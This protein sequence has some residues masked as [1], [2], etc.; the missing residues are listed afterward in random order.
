M[1][2]VGRVAVCVAVF[3]TVFLMLLIA[4]SRAVPQSAILEALDRRVT[5]VRAGTADEVADERVIQSGDRVATDVTG[6]AIVTYPDGSTALLEPG[7]ELVI[8]FVQTGTNDYIV[9]MEQTLGRVWYAV[10]RTISGGSRYEVHSQAM[11]SVIRAGSD[12]YVVVS[13]TGS[14]TVTTVSGAVET[15]AGGDEVT[16]PAG[17]STTVEA[18]SPPRAPEPALAVAPPAGATTPPPQTASPTPRPLAISQTA[19]TPTPTAAFVPPAATLPQMPLVTPPTKA[20]P[21]TAATPRPTA[22][23]TP[24]ASLK[25]KVD[26]RKTPPA[27]PTPKS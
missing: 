3:A 24:V 27:T 8:E 21:R 10:T 20:T 22:A 5:L 9:R 16:V 2:V 7:S 4:D 1:G 25:D 11:A 13:P 23:P 12:S 15:T 26:P 14:T 6:R 17:T 18:G 19:Q